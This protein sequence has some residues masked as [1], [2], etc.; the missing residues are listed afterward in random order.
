MS[1]HK[2]PAERRELGHLCF[3][4]LRHDYTVAVV[5]SGD[6]IKTAQG[7]LGHATA[8]LQKGVDM[9]TV[10][11]M[12]GHCNTGSSPRAYT[13]ATRQKQ[14]EVAATIGNFMEQVL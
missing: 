13:H 10:P 1:A 6:G 11:S 9:K 7:S 8:T 2:N 3:H 12:L 4:G 14:D 5:R